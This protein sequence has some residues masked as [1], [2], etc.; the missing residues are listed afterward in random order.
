M[1]KMLRRK[2]EEE[3]KIRES[4]KSDMERREDG[5]KVLRKMRRKEGERRKIEAS[6]RRED[7]RIWRES[8]KEMKG[9]KGERGR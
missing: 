3:R 7:L 2:E 9:R 8:F 6:G 1:R 5:G 4:R